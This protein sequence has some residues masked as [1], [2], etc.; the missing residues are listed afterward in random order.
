MYYAVYIVESEAGWG[1]RVDETVY[2]DDKQKAILFVND[3]NKVNN[4]AA[5]P[6]WYMYAEYPQQI[7]VL[8]KGAEIYKILGNK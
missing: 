5:V 3:Y 4:A 6:S 8:P 2:F 7:G 1:Q